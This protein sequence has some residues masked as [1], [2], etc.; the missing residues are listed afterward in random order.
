M[1]ED[2]KQATLSLRQYKLDDNPLNVNKQ[3][4]KLDKELQYDLLTRTERLN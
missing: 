4:E 2:Q 1:K 3:L